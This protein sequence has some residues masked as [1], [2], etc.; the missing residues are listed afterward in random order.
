MEDKSRNYERIE[1]YE[2]FFSFNIFLL[3]MA[4][5]LPP[6]NLKP[7]AKLFYNLYSASLVGVLLAG[8][9]S[10]GTALVILS[11]NL[12]LFAETLCVLSGIIIGLGD[13]IFFLY[14]KKRILHLLMKMENNL[15]SSMKPKYCHIATDAQNSLIKSS[16]IKGMLSIMIGSSFL[17]QPFMH[18]HDEVTDPDDPLRIESWNRLPYNAWIPGVDVNEVQGRLTIIFFSLCINSA[19]LMTAF[20]VDVTCMSMV[21]QVSA[22]FQYLIALLDNM[23]EEHDEWKMEMNGTGDLHILKENVEDEEDEQW[24]ENY[25]KDCIKR[26]QSILE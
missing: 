20:S 17:I 2:E 10:L 25:L 9:L 24:Y 12:T 5:L 6:I 3:R 11:G 7:L 26:H 22:Q 14:K 18:L 16:K 23:E 4:G 19:V 1:K 8:F 15:I 21:N 13:A